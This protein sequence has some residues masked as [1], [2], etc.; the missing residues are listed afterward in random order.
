MEH[1]PIIDAAAKLVALY[2][3]PFG[4]KPEGRYRLSPKMLRQITGRKKL[5]EA[6]MRALAEELFERG[7]V[8]LDL[9]TY[10]GVASVKTFANYRRLSEASLQETDA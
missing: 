10:Y 9:E 1:D 2:E 8:L 7:Y 5:S 4:G 6:Y 3:R